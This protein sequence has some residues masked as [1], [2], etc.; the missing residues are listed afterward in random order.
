MMKI[1][2]TIVYKVL[3]I[4]MWT[5]I[6][7]GLMVLLVSAVRKERTMVCKAVQVEFTDSQPFRMLDEMEIISTL[8]PDQ[9]KAFPQGK[10][11]VSVDLYAL[12]RQL[13]KNPWI[14]SADLFFD[15][16]HVLHINV[17]QRTPVARLFTPAGSSVYMD[18]SFTVL[19]VKIN[20]IVSLP[21]FSNFSIN[22]A[23]AN[24]KDSLVM[25]RITG[26]AQFILADPFWMAQIE[27][28][29]I[30]ADHSFELVTQV[31]DQAIRLGNRSD[32]A[33]MLDKLKMFYR[34]ISD[35]NGWTKYATIDLQFKDQIV[36]VK[37]TGLYQVPD[38]TVQMDSLKAVAIA[39]STV[40]IKNN[41]QTITPVKSKL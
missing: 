36:C 4:L 16:H 23:G 6:S 15:Q 10:K 37:G 19:P 2:M 7:A 17:Q 20:D 13:E 34:R 3:T 1:K 28:V 30:N 39:D 11:L 22:P 9:K 41:A 25:Q 18:E 21:V 31:G 40:N 33:A 26:L 29:N 8:W 5:A 27:Q 32:W 12:E 38:S 35:E 24:A 14:F